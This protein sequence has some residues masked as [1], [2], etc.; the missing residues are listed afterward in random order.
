MKKS[1]KKLMGLL[2]VFVLFTGVFCISN[3]AHATTINQK[4]K[5]LTV[6]NNS[7]YVNQI[8]VDVTYVVE[9]SGST[10]TKC[11]ASVNNAASSKY[12]IGINSCTYSGTRFSVSYSL[13]LKNDEFVKSATL[14]GSI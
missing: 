9:L 6:Y 7:E 4:T 13:Y 2:M 14:S 12:N 5:Y 11:S 1:S 8:K 10:I 3:T